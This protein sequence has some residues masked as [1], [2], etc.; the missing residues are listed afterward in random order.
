MS[1][2]GQKVGFI[3]GGNMGEAL[4][5]GLLAANLVPPEAIH[6]SDVRIEASVIAIAA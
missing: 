3:G 1:I 2:K 5:K 6:A 4:I